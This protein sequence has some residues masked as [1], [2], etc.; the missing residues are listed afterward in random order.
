MLL[1]ISMRGGA[2]VSLLGS[3]PEDRRFESVPRYHMGPGQID[4]PKTQGARKGEP[5]ICESSGLNP[6]WPLILIGGYMS[7]KTRKYFAS[8]TSIGKALKDN[9]NIRIIA[10]KKFITLTDDEWQFRQIYCVY[11][12]ESG[13][14]KPVA[15]FRTKNEVKAVTELLKGYRRLVLGG[16]I[17]TGLIVQKWPQKQRRLVI[18]PKEYYILVN[19]SCF[20][21]SE[22]VTEKIKEGWKPIGGISVSQEHNTK[23]PRGIAPVYAQ[24][25]IKRK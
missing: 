8:A 18:P 25:M 16:T 6:V 21:L 15:L 10:G 24:A 23:W 13:N 2:V 3:Y 1:D 17:A 12:T 9:N 22:I 7:K 20:M 19:S 11:K 14:K 5:V 4:S